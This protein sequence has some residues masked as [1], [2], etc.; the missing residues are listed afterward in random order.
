ME[1]GS[2][3]YD[4]ID[5]SEYI[6][7]YL[8]GIKDIS[9]INKIDFTDISFS[10]NEKDILENIDN[11]F[12]YDS[13][14]MAKDYPFSYLHNSGVMVIEPNKNDYDN[15]IELMKEKSNNQIQ[16]GDQDI[17]NEYFKTINTIPQEYNLMRLLAKYV[18]NNNTEIWNIRKHP[19]K[20]YDDKNLNKKIRS[21]IINRPYSNYNLLLFINSSNACLSL[22]LITRN[23]FIAGIT[24]L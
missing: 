16:L 3:Y 5:A 13:I 7:D 23:S 19:I 10:Y 6:K 14:A 21:I 2:L 9:E 24:V 18:K 17:I 20:E 4:S 22:I 11:L 8:D 1:S 15:L 12:E